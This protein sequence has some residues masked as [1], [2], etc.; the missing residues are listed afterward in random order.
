MPDVA[1]SVGKTRLAASLERIEVIFIFVPGCF[2]IIF[3]CSFLL[4]YGLDL[5]LH[6]F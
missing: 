3:S 4:E 5:L 2:N 6:S 1:L